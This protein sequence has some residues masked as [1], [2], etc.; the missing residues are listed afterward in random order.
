MQMALAIVALQ[1]L[2]HRKPQESEKPRPTLSPRGWGTQPFYCAMNCYS[3]IL[4]SDVRS[5]T[6]LP[7]SDRATQI[8]KLT[9]DYVEYELPGYL[10]NQKGMYQIG[11]DW[12]GDTFVITHRF[13]EPIK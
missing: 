5:Q 4:T 12:I 2:R 10:N 1:S 11:G 9:G 13:F 7:V 8:N 3:G 6:D